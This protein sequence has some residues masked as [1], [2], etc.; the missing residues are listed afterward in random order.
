MLRMDT[1][2][3]LPILK[4]YQEALAHWEKTKPIRGDVNGTKPVG[5]RDQKFFA[6]WKRGADQAICVGYA[7]HSREDGKA[8]LAYHPD[9]RVAIEKHI[10]AS[11]RERIQRIAGIIIQRRHNEDWV[12][13]KTYQDGEEVRGHF[14]LK[15]AHKN[16]RVATFI[17]Q[18]NAT[19]IYIN[20]VPMHTHTINKQGKAAVTAK[21]KEFTAYVKNIAKLM[22]GRVPRLQRSEMYD[23]HGLVGEIRTDYYALSLFKGYWHPP[24]E[25]KANKRKQLFVMATSGD[26]EQMY[27]AMLWVSFTSNNDWHNT[28]SVSVSSWFATFEKAVM[29]QHKDEVLTR[30]EV[31]DGRIVRDR[32]ASYGHYY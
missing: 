26:T 19:P 6:I 17:L 11:C 23:M 25:E 14:P 31:R 30:T 16:S 9:G 4:S 27:K 15:L 24:S 18:G 8:L 32:Y 22:D 13:A 28:G 20:P 10:S 2:F 1:Y 29:V 5:R 3:S 7:W 12:S 21:F